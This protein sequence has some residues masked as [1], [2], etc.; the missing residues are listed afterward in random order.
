[1]IDIV[2]NSIGFLIALFSA[3]I[4]NEI[5]IL[6]FCGFNKNTKKFVNQRLDEELKE[7]IIKFR[8]FLFLF[9]QYFYLYININI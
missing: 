8:I 5:I 7:I 6:N 1:M 3:L 9:Y 4:Y 2:L